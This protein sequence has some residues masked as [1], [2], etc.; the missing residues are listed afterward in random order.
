MWENHFLL[1]VF[2]VVPSPWAG[3]C[4]SSQREEVSVTEVSGPRESSRESCLVFLVGRN[5]WCVVHVNILS[6]TVSGTLGPPSSPNT[7]SLLMAAVT[8][9]YMQYSC[10][11]LCRCIVESFSNQ[12]ETKVPWM[13]YMGD[14]VSILLFLPLSHPECVLQKDLSITEKWDKQYSLFLVKQSPCFISLG[15]WRGLIAW[16]KLSQQKLVQI[17]YLIT[18]KHSACFFI[19]FMPMEVAHYWCGEITAWGCPQRAARRGGHG[20]RAASVACLNEALKCLKLFL[21]WNIP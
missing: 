1:L 9:L 8:L 16:E 13:F 2:V 21:K 17:D 5:K 4:R 7:P 19:I 6:F 10:N 11:F 14:S 20:T 3:V 18:N 12:L 15:G